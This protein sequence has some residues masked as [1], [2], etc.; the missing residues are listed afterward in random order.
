M[1]DARRIVENLTDS[2]A[3]IV[4]HHGIALRLGVALDGVA[5]ITERGTWLDHVDSLPKGIEGGFAQIKLLGNRLVRK[6]HPAAVA[7]PAI[8]D[9]RDVDVQDVTPRQPGIA[10][11]AVADDSFKEMQVDFG[12]PR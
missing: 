5:E 12:N 7:I 11:N 2:M 1:E 9:D 6:I 4:T 8:E 10:R 3:A